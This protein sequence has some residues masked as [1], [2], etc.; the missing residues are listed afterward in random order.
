MAPFRQE[1]R[2]E[3]KEESNGSEKGE[4]VPNGTFP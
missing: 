2:W 4:K 1:K 3:N